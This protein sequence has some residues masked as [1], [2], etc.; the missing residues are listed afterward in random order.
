[1][2][3]QTAS[4]FAFASFLSINILAMSD[5]HDE[6]DKSVVV[7]FVDNPV[8][9]NPNAPSIAARQF[10]TA[11]RAWVISKTADRSNDALPILVINLRK[12]L[13]G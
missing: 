5:D 12:L 10:R 3:A 4:Y 11:C 7:N 13:L 2:D 1:M 9:A 6:N 8:G